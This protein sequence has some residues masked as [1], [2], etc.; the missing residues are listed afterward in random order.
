MK[1]GNKIK[2][3]SL[4]ALGVMTSLPL[5]AAVDGTIDS[6]SSEGVTN[7]GLF[8]EPVIK[9]SGVEDLIFSNVNQ[10]AIDL[11]YSETIEMSFCVYSNSPS[12]AL[13]FDF[14]GTGALNNGERG[15]IPP[16]QNQGNN[17]LDDIPDGDIPIDNYAL[18]PSNNI[19]VS[20]ELYRNE[21]FNGSVSSTSLVL[22]SIDKNTQIYGQSSLV[23]IMNEDCTSLVN[24]E[25]MENYT[26]KATIEGGNLLMATGGEFNEVMYITAIYD[27]TMPV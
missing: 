12:F 24:N 27:G 15:F 18:F 7:V 9:I 11:T 13:S 17:F 6:F 5:L 21:I 20:Y 23:E 26:I 25:K 16:H 3:F 19:P 10:S 22:E 1:K 2:S 14:D 8:I 4:I